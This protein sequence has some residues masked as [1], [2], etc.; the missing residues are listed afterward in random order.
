MLKQLTLI[1]YPAHIP[2]G[3]NPTAPYFVL[4]T[5]QRTLLINLGENE[6]ANLPKGCEKVLGTEAY[7]YLLEIICGLKSKLLG[8]NEIVNQFKIAYKE[9]SQHPKRQTRLIVILEKLFKDSKV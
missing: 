4:K 1:N 5:C 6:V 7:Q 9:Y 2:L 8:E 3:F